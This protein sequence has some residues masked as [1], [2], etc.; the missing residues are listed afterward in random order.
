MNESTYFFYVLGHVFHDCGLVYIF[1]PLLMTGF[2]IVEI[3]Y[4]KTKQ[5]TVR[6]ADFQ[7]QK[8]I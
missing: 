2:E 1:F 3:I 5:L 8:C 7:D 6:Y 4:K